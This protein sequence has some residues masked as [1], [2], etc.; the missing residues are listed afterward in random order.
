[1]MLELTSFDA[2]PPA[3]DWPKPPIG[4]PFIDSAYG[5]Q[6][7]RLT[8]A[9]GTRFNRNTYSRRQAE[10]ADGTLFLTYHG[11]AEYRVYDRATLDLVRTLDVHPDG[12]PQWHPTDAD[13]IR[14]VAGGNSY[15]GDLRWY[16]TS[17]STGATS[18]IADLTD[19]I[20]DRFP[21]ALY[22]KD[23]AEG[24]PSADGDRMAWVVFDETE[25]PIG[26]VSYDLATD[27]VLGAIDITTSSDD[28]GPIDWVSM[29]PT[30]TYVMAGHWDAT[31]VYDADL[32]NGRRVNNK[33]DHS[34]MA[35]SAAGTD[36]Y[37]YID[38]S[39]GPDGGW[40][41]AVDLSTLERTRLVDLYEDANTSIHISGKGYDRPGWVV[42]S[43][44]NC[45]VPGAWSC[46]KVMLVGLGETG[47]I[48]DLAHTYNC[49]D[50]YWTETHAVV[51]RSFTRVYFNSDAGSCGMDAEVYELTLP[52]LPAA[53]A[54]SDD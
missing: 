47:R 54:A 30:G 33:A 49:G 37:V 34:D 17:I 10:N 9:D 5:T 12:E 11:E 15:V 53:A 18:V 36:A 14:S 13:L 24:S 23:Q 26:L 40:L 52:T 50:N 3:A 22:I 39:A 1:M 6:I 31:I 29:S 41:V 8:S 51:N 16:E 32:T 43:T 46:E 48:Y 19:R 44:Y 4:E 20:V 45:K 2:T 7:R 27:Q 25:N 38:F 35:L 28:A 42:V 21:T